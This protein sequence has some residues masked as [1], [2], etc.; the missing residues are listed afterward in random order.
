MQNK[1]KAKEVSLFLDILEPE[2]GENFA[3]RKWVSA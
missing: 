1:D 3:K 2:K